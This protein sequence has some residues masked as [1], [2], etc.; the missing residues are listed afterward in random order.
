M[1][2]EVVVIIGVLV[3]FG[4]AFLA[5]W[6]ADELGRPPR[7]WFLLSLVLGPVA[8]IALGFAGR[9]LDHAFKACVTCREPI[10]E[11]ATTCPNCRADLTGAEPRRRKP[12]QTLH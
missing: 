9:G 10:H 5:N 11:G 6:L 7:D 4:I 12:R 3:W 8:L 1:S 2:L